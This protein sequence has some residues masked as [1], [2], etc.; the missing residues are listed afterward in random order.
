[1]KAA[2]M[3]GEVSHDDAEAHEASAYYTAAVNLSLLKSLRKVCGL[4]LLRIE[5]EP[6]PGRLLCAE[7]EI[8]LGAGD[9]GRPR[10]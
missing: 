7:M 9:P 6:V 2:L 10:M 8:P 5:H 4:A 3:G 1:M